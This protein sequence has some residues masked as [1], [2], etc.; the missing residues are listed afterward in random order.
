MTKSIARAW[1]KDGIKAFAVAPGF[2]RTAMAEQV[3]AEKGEAPLLNELALNELTEPEDVSP[4]VLY[5]ASGT[6]DHATGSTIDINGGSY[7]R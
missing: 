3:I 7:V 1:G 6:M 5:L 4:I 2:V